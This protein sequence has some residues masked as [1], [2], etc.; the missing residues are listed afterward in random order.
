MLKRYSLPVRLLLLVM[1]L[2]A[3]STQKAPVTT[4][5][6]V[7]S[8]WAGKSMP[9]DVDANDGRQLFET[10]CQSCHGPRGAGDG[11][12]G[13]SLVPPPSNLIELAPLVRD[14]F[15]FW[16]INTGVEGTSMPA[17]GNIL[18]ELEIWQL[19]AFIRTLR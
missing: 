17:W 18:T 2:G 12:A 1:I 15:L 7:P 11:A 13:A 19:V 4:I 3:C 16:R 10:Y 14:D 6:P 8:A 5:L 9:A